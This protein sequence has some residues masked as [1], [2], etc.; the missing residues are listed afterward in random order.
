[1]KELN[2]GDTSFHYRF[3]HLQVSGLGN[4]IGVRAAFRFGV[5][6]K[7]EPNINSWRVIFKPGRGSA[8][9]ERELEKHQSYICKFNLHF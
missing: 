8:G 1:M 3:I 4:K 9:E 5:L 6:S 2:E 7:F